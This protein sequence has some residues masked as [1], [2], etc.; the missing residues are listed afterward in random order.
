MLR[1]LE[2][3][4][5][6]QRVKIISMR[7]N[8]QRLLC[9]LCCLVYRCTSCKHGSVWVNYDYLT[10]GAYPDGLKSLKNAVFDV[11]RSVVTRWKESF[12][13]TRNVE[14]ANNRGSGL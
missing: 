5:S 14:A 1:S 9:F 4:E 3:R 7:Q 13:I 12:C 11:Q 10:F 8:K 6:K 2:S